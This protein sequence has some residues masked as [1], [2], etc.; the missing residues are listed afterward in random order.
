[1]K[2]GEL[3][4]ALRKTKGNPTVVVELVPGKRFDLII[5]KTPFF[6]ELDKHFP[7]GKAVE[8][9]LSFDETSGIVR[10]EGDATA[11][12]VRTAVDE[13]DDFFLDDDD[14]VTSAPDD[15]CLV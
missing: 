15:D 7:G 2:L 1:M 13:D 6:E 3:R 14:A 10:F 5:Q 9:G 11:A 4:A 8:T 12:V